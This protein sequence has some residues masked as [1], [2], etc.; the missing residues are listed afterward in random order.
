V[1]DL[2]RG[3]YVVNWRVVSAVDGH[4]TAGAFAFGVQTE[5]TGRPPSVDAQTTT[6]VLEIAGRTG[7]LFGLIVAL[8][9]ATYQL[10]RLGDARWVRFAVAGLLTAAGGLAVLIAAQWR[11]GGAPLPALVGTSIGQAWIAR[12]AA[13]A[14][15]LIGVALATAWPMNRVVNRLGAIVIWL[16]ACGAIAVHGFAGHA[17]AGRWPVAP[18]VIVH[19]IHVVAAGIWI[20]SLAIMIAG[21]RSSVDGA[22]ARLFARFSML[23]AIGIALVTF[24]GIVRSVQEVDSWQALATT[25]YGTLVIA[26]VTL[27]LAI[28]TLGAMN[29]WRHLPAAVN[30][31]QPLRRTARAE[32]ALAIVAIVAASALATL[33]PPA[34]AT[35]L[36]GIQASGADFATT[37]KATLRAASDQPGP[38]RFSVAVE[39]Y[40]SGDAVSPDRIGLRFTPIDDA[41]IAPTT[42]ALSKDADGAFSGTGANVTFDGRWHVDVLIERGSSSVDVPLEIEARGRPRLVSVL[43]VP[44][45][46]PIYTIDLNPLGSVQITVDP[47]RPGETQLQISCVTVFA[48]PLPV[49]EMVVTSENEEVPA[50]SLVLTRRDRHRFTAETALVRGNNRLVVIA[51]TDSGAR[52]RA[53]LPLNL[54]ERGL[55]GP[56]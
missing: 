14:I 21:L 26:K 55:T 25:A 9:A 27:L 53:V 35:V 17:A 39:D 2:P 32:I 12:A 47:E 51:R 37:V 34:A 3:V 23:A 30:N 28:A 19:A 40:D 13:I 56:S 20:G 54:P 10:L 24:A 33:P 6:P 44:N 43:R 29:R 49:L 52:L 7:F 45:Q 4:A 8:G 1:R 18:A 16:A 46:A 42:L 38:N 11:A 41:G 22:H 48:E 50:H 31:T 15:A 5:P 36:P